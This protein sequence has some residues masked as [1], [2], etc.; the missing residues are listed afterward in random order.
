MPLKSSRRRFLNLCLIGGMPLPLGLAG[1]APAA[2]DC[3][4]SGWAIAPRSAGQFFDCYQMSVLGDVADLIVGA[5]AR[6]SAQDA[7]VI[8]YIDGMMDGWAGPAL[9]ARLSR[10]PGYL[11]SF[12]A[13]HAGRN[14]PSILGETRQQ[15]LA[16]F[17][18]DAF[19]EQGT[20]ASTIYREF[21]SLLLHVYFSSA[22]TNRDYVGLPGM[23][24][25]D[26]S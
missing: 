21:K 16:G 6:A 24:D 14:Y 26:L 19:A 9:K 1:C 23:Y 8:G 15:T 2:L 13:D 5:G 17:D 12:S 20:D 11:D 4:T 7:G 22:E 3:D 18:A 10:L 25:G